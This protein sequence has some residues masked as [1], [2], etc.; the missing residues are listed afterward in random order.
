TAAAEFRCPYIGLRAHTLGVPRAE[1]PKP[2]ARSATT[3]RTVAARSRVGVL[4]ACS[5]YTYGGRAAAFRGAS[6]IAIAIP[7]KLRWFDG[8]MCPRELARACL[9]VVRSTRRARA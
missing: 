1:P 5:A 3:I 2:V 8:S 4:A 6:A 9:A 7:L